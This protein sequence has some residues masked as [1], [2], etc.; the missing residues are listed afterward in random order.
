[1]SN[2]RGRKGKQRLIA[3]IGLILVAAMLVT[4]LVVYFV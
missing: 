4:S 2:Y 1:M 3:L